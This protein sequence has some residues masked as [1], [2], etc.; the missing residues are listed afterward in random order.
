M[1]DITRRALLSGVT[2]TAATAAIGSILAAPS[3]AMSDPPETPEQTFSK[4]S[5]FLTGIDEK[6]LGPDVDPLGLNHEIFTR[7]DEKNASTLQVMFQEFNAAAT[8]DERQAAVGSMMAKPALGDQQAEKIR[9]LGRSIILAWYLGA[10]YDPEDLKR[11]FYDAASRDQQYYSYRRYSRN[12]LIPHVILSANAY[13]A[14]LVWR[15]MQAHPMGYS[16]LQFGY[17]AQSPPD[18]TAFI[19]PIG[20]PK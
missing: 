13:T 3:L 6:I 4:L 12:V 19:K 18:I 8:D 16:N 20:A 11:H 15:A 14:S 17:W 2:A 1:T 9:F 10:W 7:V 5:A